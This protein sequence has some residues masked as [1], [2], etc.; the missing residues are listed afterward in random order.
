MNMIRYVCF[1]VNII[2]YKGVLEWLYIL[3]EKCLNI[4]L[5]KWNMSFFIGSYILFLV[6]IR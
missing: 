6:N 1:V 2:L 4:I 3:F 5:Y